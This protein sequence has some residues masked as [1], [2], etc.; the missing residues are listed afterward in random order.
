MVDGWI[1]KKD[2]FLGVINE[3][4]NEDLASMN[5]TATRWTPERTLLLLINGNL[6]FKS[7]SGLRCDRHIRVRSI[8]YDVLCL[9]R[10]T[11]ALLSSLIRY[12]RRGTRSPQLKELG[13]AVQYT[14]VHEIWIEKATVRR[15]RRAKEKLICSHI[16]MSSPIENWW[17]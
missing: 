16:T 11:A 15:T 12:Y 4:L 3:L 8:M 13:N 1:L 2:L 14:G 17:W 9:C 7:G 10:W 5:N 6:Y